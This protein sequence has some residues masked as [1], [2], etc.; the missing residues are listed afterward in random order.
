MNIM[1]TILEHTKVIG[2]LEK[3]KIETLNVDSFEEI[4]GHGVIGKIGNKEII[5]GNR[6]I[7][8][9]FEIEN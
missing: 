7:L 5:L 8:L 1:Q 6:K 9:K 3:N 4:S 2:N